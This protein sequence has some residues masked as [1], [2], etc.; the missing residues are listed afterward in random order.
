M[1]FHSFNVLIVLALFLSLLGSAVTVTPAYAAGILVNTAVDED[2]NNANCSLREAIIAANT[3][4]AYN[5][6]TAGAGADTISFDANYTITL[7]GSQLPAITSQITINGNGASN[8]IIQASICNPVTLP[9]GCTP[10]T[11][12]VF[13]VSASGT[14]TLDSLTVR[15]GRCNGLMCP[16]GP[17]LGGGIFNNNGTLTVTNSTLSGNSADG[18]GSIYNNNGTLTITN[19]TLSGNSAGGG[20]GGIYNS[21]GTLIITNSTLSNNSESS[22]DG[23]GIYNMGTLTVTN[24]LFSENS[25][26]RGGVI[27][28]QDTATVTNSTFSENSAS[29]GG[30]IFNYA[31]I[32]LTN[33]TFSENSAGFG[34]SIL[35]LG[36]TLNY[37]NTIIANSLSGGDCFDAGSI[38]TNTNN[39]VEDSTCSP[40]LSG[41]P[42]LS[43][44]QNNG[45]PTQTHALLSGSTAIDA[46]NAGVCPATDQR[47]VS[48]PLDGDATPGAVCDIGAFE[49][50]SDNTFPTV[51]FN[52]LVASYAAGAGPS[53][54]TVNFSEN[55]Y[56]PAGNTNEDDVTN[57][58]NYLVVEDGAN[59][60]FNTVS[61]AGGVTSDDVQATITSITYNAGLYTATVNLSGALPGG[62]YRLFVCGTTSIADTV[63]NTLNNGLSDYTFDFTVGGTGTGTSTGTGN[64]TP[65]TTASALP[66]TGFA[67]NKV[68]TLAAQPATLEYAKLGDLVLEIPSLN[69]KST[70]VGVPQNADSTWDVTWLG[71]NIGWLNDTAFPTWEGNS[72]LTAHVTNA[73]GLPGIFANL[74]GLQYGDQI[75]IHLS[76]QKY[77]FEVSQ[78]KLVRPNTTAFAFEDLDDKSYLTLITCQGYNSLNDTYLFRRVVRAVLVS[79][80]NE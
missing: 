67:P 74:K 5:G 64:P 3:N 32:T 46:G 48:R 65:A 15:H 75:I 58:D 66:K 54:F 71:N 51:V 63:L 38:G 52:S 36:G 10:A 6:C 61:C 72:V 12:R 25:A 20:G 49:Y 13:E 47:G 34:G 23:G 60:T 56:D 16:T 39:L 19:S 1:K 31:T 7:V 78:S 26:I 45:G 41:D 50:S 27:V 8:T 4:A 70:I 62:S 59:D 73:S 2:T 9:G 69:V 55:V 17:N 24:S 14:L 22:G 21:N 80:E 11:Y 53:N 29:L 43:P 40:A 42:N 18:G 33:S 28:N 37:S 30:A 76:G 77:I 79:V 57:P 44:L 68:T 35:N